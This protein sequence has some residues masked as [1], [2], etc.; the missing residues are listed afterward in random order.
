MSG[1]WP[2]VL[3][4]D[5]VPANIRLLAEGLAS[6]YEILFAT[7]GAEAL[8]IAEE[9][10][11]DLV[12]LDVMMP[13]MDGYA[14]CSRLKAR[15]ETEGIPIIFVTAATEDEYEL[16]GLVLGAADYIT[17]PV[18]LPIVRVRVRNLV[19]RYR[20][21][22][23]L[24]LAASVFHGAT[25]GILVTDTDGNIID[26]NPA[27]CSMTGYSREE[28][29]GR[30]PRL[31]KSDRQD[32]AFYQRFWDALLSSGYWSG[33]IWNRMRHGEVRPL[34]LNVAAVRKSNGRISH[35]VALFSDIQ[36]LMEHQQQLEHLAYHD[37]LTDIPNRVLLADR[38]QQAI[39]Q[40]LRYGHFLAVGMLDLD[41]FKAIN[42]RWGHAAGDQILIEVA[43]RLGESCRA[44]DT[45]AR[46]GGD[47]FVLL[48]IGL[49]RMEECEATATRLLQRLA[50]PIC[51]AE[52]SVTLTASIGIAICPTHCSGADELLVAA[53]RAMYIAKAAGKNGYQVYDPALE[54][55]Q[56]R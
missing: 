25:E 20:A 17:K 43:R 23:Q 44:G 54:P 32:A 6:E 55:D 2:T 45:L 38:L 37:A 24:R 21:E 41:G 13:E 36:S 22:E 46:F 34:L 51:R 29:L 14:V 11:P 16:R 35:F 28:L 30:N 33:Q 27:F 56:Q 3:I 26:V 47:E 19:Q 1:R 53:D 52:V 4:V 7:S 15:P 8:R 5:D 12:L 42:D 49:S 18:N 39:P 31:L 40:T 48:W 50:E 10:R 9:Q